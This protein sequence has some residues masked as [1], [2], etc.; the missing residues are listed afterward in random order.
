MGSAARTGAARAAAGRAAI[1]G[2]AAVARAAGGRVAAEG[3]W[4][5]GAAGRGVGG[6][7]LTCWG[8]V[9]QS[10]QQHLEGLAC[11]IA[12]VQVCGNGTTPA[13]FS[14]GGFFSTTRGRPVCVPE[15]VGNLVGKL[16]VEARARARAAGVLAGGAVSE[17]QR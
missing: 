10:Q 17:Q 13:V 3:G 4:G 8:R 16:H 14:G 7:C 1:E 6:R 2:Q 11:R 15:Y 9:G 12:G 5:C